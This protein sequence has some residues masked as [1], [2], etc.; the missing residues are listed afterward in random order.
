MAGETTTAAVAVATEQPAGAEGATALTQG[1]QSNTAETNAGQPVGTE[2][3]Q[4]EENKD[5]KSVTPEAYD[6]KFPEKDYEVDAGLVKDFSEFAKQKGWDNKTAQE[7]IDF[8]VNKL[9]PIRQAQ[10]QKAFEAMSDQWLAEAKADKEIGGTSFNE[11][12][13]LAVK[14][15]EKFGSPELKDILNYSQVGN[16]P[17]VI[18]FFS[19]IG[20]AMSDSDVMLGGQNGAVKSRLEDRLF[21]TMKDS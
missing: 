6:F 3:P 7:M 2:T 19:K 8:Q 4:T 18:K 11:N 20:K 17:A 16:H 21:T 13:G 10:Q 15:I 12:V 5:A 14:A 1:T 9:E